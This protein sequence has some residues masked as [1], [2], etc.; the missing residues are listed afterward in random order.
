[1]SKKEQNNSNQQSGQMSFLGHLEEMRWRLVRSAISVV[2]V[3]IVIFIFTEPIVKTVFM[4]MKEADFITYKLLCDLGN[5]IGMGDGMCI[6]SIQIK[7]IQSLD[8]TGQFNTNMYMALIGGVIVAFPFI[9]WQMWGFVKPALKEKEL[10]VSKGV[11]F[12]A[13]VLFF[14]GIGFGYFLISPLCV[15]FFGNYKILEDV[16]NNFRINSYLSM[17]STTTFLTGLFFELPVVIYIATKLGLVSPEWLKKYRRHAI[18]VVLILSALITPPDVISQVM[19]AIPIMLLYESGI[20]VSKAV[21]R[22]KQEV[23]R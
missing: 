18:V 10:N 16:D 19:V 5:M 8:M 2:A 11:I 20:Y 3:A 22:R 23:K 13:S 4:N 12:W 7:S 17:I 6:E 15:Q 14:L 1:M 21:V 9:F